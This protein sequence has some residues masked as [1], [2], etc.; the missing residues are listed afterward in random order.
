MTTE[1]I[2]FK[3]LSKMVNNKDSESLGRKQ[4][5]ATKKKIAAAV[6]GKKNPAYKNGQ[7]SYRNKI[8][9]KP[10]QHVHHKDGNR[11][12]NDKSN[13]ETFPAK[14]P[15]RAAHEKKHNRAANFSKSGGRKKVKSGGK[16]KN[17]NKKPLKKQ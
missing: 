11:S 16:A 1:K 7:R 2:R 9:A 10:G 6:T 8:K 3:D 14:G 17:M 13:L 15:G 12:N 4:T 5:A